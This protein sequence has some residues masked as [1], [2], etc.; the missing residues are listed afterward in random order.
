MLRKINQEKLYKLKKNQGTFSTKAVR[1]L[2]LNQD[3][4]LAR[5]GDLFLDAENNF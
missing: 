5:R 2:H 4:G 1:T 3:F